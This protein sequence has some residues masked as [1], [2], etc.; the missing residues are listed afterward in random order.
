MSL[1]TEDVELEYSVLFAILKNGTETLRDVK[2]LVEE[3]DFTVPENRKIYSKLLELY[4]ST[5]SLPS[6]HGVI[7]LLL[8][9]EQTEDDKVKIKL[10]LKK[11]VKAVIEQKD[12]APVC[13][14]VREYRCVREMLKLFN[15]TVKNAETND[16]EYLLTDIQRGVHDI[17]ALKE[18][19]VFKGQMGILEMLEKRKEYVTDV[20]QNPTKNGLIRTGF[21][22]IDSHIP[23]HS[24]GNFV[25]YQARTNTGKSMFLMA[26]ALH[27][28]L[29]GARVLII[30]IEMNEYD[31][32]F[33]IDS[34][35]TSFKHED[36]ASGN[37][38]DD[39]IKMAVWEQKIK[40]CDKGQGDLFVY[41]VPE[42]C[43]P[44]KI[45][46]IISNHPFKP[47]LVIVDYAGDMKAGLRGVPDFS[48]TAQGEIYSRLKEIAGKFRCVIYSAQQT[49]RNVKQID[50]ESGSW[51]DVA[52]YKAD[53]MIAI[54]KTKDDELEKI[55]DPVYGN[56]CDRMTINIIKGRNVPKVTTRLYERFARM[57]WFE[58]DEDPNG[59]FKQ[60]DPKS[61]AETEAEYAQGEAPQEEK[62]ELN[63]NQEEQV[64]FSALDGM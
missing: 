42:R 28:W 51:S 3:K 36:F 24:P 10:C 12:V 4:S 31:Y 63:N 52:S 47:D 57:S 37:I 43:T 13:K 6:H 20:K 59:G 11:I 34:N 15:S 35:V 8:S 23:P 40:A 50:T 61:K 30:T 19:T 21:K 5:G 29:N 25:L 9:E 1:I 41:W 7:K 26:T 44:D 48:P 38:S 60:A 39:K 18:Q 16:L 62:V 64:D 17:R 2:A 58:V 14:K 53:I 27:N 56:E 45:E 55:V 49:R 22:W 32:A 33:R 46:A 54:Q